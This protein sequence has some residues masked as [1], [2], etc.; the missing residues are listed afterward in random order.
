MKKI[1]KSKQ[2]LF[3]SFK[4]ITHW[5]DEKKLTIL[6][7]RMVELGMINDSTI[8]F[9]RTFIISTKISEYKT[10]NKKNMQKSDY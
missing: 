10:K 7:K 9:Q 2:S 5:V 1:F 6:L 4:Q 8:F 3:R